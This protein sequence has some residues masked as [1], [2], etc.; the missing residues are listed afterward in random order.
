MRNRAFTLIELLVVIAIIAILAAILFP[1]FA[2][3]REKA[4][5]TSCLSNIKQTSLGMLM[6]VQDYDEEL[7]KA[8]YWLPTGSQSPLNPNATGGFS[9]RVNHYKWQTW[10]IPYIKNTDVL[11]CPSRTRDQEAWAVNGEYK[12]DGFAFNLSLSGRPYIGGVNPSFLGGG[13][14]GIQEPAS[15]WMFQE[16]RNQISF[17]YETTNYILYPV[18]DRES[19]QPYLMP[20]GQPDKINAPH[21]DGFNFAYVDG[22]AK[23][24]NVKQFL[25]LC[26]TRAEYIVPGCGLRTSPGAQ[27]GFNVCRVTTPPSWTRPF[28]FWGLQ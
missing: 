25:A 12:G 7:P 8:D 19:W 9:L 15:V 20:N 27:A 17:S 24:M 18:A 11:R 5:Q 13:L 1:V 3:A 6:Y 26:P 4:R 28:P 16:L 23:W 22:H 10:V 2:Q 21:S 14:A